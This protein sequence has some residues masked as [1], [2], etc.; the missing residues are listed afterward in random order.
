MA[1][2]STS[3]W[4]SADNPALTLL[5]D[6]HLY[7]R[8]TTTLDPQTNLNTL[9]NRMSVSSISKGLAEIAGGVF[10][11]VIMDKERMALHLTTD[12]SGLMPLYYL[13]E[14]DGFHFSGNPFTFADKCPIWEPALIEF[15]KFGFL[16]FSDSFFDGIRRVL[17]GQLISVPLNENW[18]QKSGAYVSEFL[19]DNQ[20]ITNPDEAAGQ[21]YEALEGFYHRLGHAPFSLFVDGEPET[22]L[23]LAALHGEK[24]FILSKTGGPRLCQI[25]KSRDLEFSVISE[26]PAETSR[27]DDLPGG[28]LA[29]SSEHRPLLNGIRILLNKGHRHALDDSRAASWMRNPVHLTRHKNENART[30]IQPLQSYQQFLYNLPGSLPDNL[31]GGIMNREFEVWFLNNALGVLENN[32]TAG[33]NHFDFLESL[34]RYTVGRTLHNLLFLAGGEQP[35]FLS[36][37]NDY[38]VQDVCRNIDRNLK[39]HGELTRHLVASYYPTFR[40]VMEQIFNPGWSGLVK[41]FLAP[42]RQKQSQAVASMSNGSHQNSILKISDCPAFPNHFCERLQ[43]FAGQGPLPLPLSHRIDTLLRFFRPQGHEMPYNIN[44]VTGIT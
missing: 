24:P 3:P 7:L 20:R 14:Q 18:N 33:D 29:I 34:E 44:K 40:E 6:G 10:A 17:P 19:P 41:R 30:P 16:P 39:S 35:L 37:F 21:L 42:L 5:L 11:L 43:K 4:I 25:L 2:P 28:R 15:L 23:S 38:R 27:P 31:L 32:R 9:L 13:E 36:P 8:D 12:R 22:L 26:S 1:S